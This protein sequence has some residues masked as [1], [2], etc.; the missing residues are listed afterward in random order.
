MSSSRIYTSLSP[1]KLH[2]QKKYFA[3]RNYN[4]KFT[5][6]SIS[7]DLMLNMPIWRHPAVNKTL[8]QSACHR[9]AVTYLRLNHEV[10]TVK[11]VVYIVD[12]RTAVPRKPH[13]V[14]P[15]GCDRK[16]LWLPIMLPRPDITGLR[17]S[18]SMY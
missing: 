10:Q 9:D 6:L 17:T 4:L 18:R 11:D 13:Q 16:K 3:V 1:R 5:G 12:Q 7:K 8:Y 15:S 14:N 2:Y